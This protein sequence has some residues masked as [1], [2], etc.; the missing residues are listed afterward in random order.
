MVM[1]CGC[2]LIRTT[3]Q[4]ESKYVS[5]LLAYQDTVITGLL[6]TLFLPSNFHVSEFTPRRYNT[7]AGSYTYNILHYSIIE[8]RKNC[9]ITEIYNCK[10]TAKGYIEDMCIR[11]YENIRNDDYKCIDMGRYSILTAN[12]IYKEYELLCSVDII[13]YAYICVC[14]IE[15]CLKECLLKS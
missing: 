1:S 12:T 14:K 7:S 11:I 5:R 8:I 6:C 9:K 13:W 10:I 15:K 2:E 3:C 4:W